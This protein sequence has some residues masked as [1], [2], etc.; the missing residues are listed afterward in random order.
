[1][2]RALLATLTCTLVVVLGPATPSRGESGPAEN[3][4]NARAALEALPY[5]FE[6]QQPPRDRRRALIIRITDELHRSFRFFLFVGRVPL[7][8]GVPRYHRGHLAAGTLGRRYVLLSNEAQE[9]RPM[10]ASLPIR[11]HKGGSGITKAMEDEY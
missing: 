4:P 6:F 2:R 10:S 7:D 1:M 3:I 9:I 11:S 8:L 5:P